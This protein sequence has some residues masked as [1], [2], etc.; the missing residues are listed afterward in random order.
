MNEQQRRYLEIFEIARTGV[1][2]IPEIEAKASFVADVLNAFLRAHGFSI[3]L[4]PCAPD[5][6]GVAAVF[7]VVLAWL[8]WKSTH[9]RAN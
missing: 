5:E 4:E 6:F 2:S 9:H 8:D 1:G 7:E 3:A